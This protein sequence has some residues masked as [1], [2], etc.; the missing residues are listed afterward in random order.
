VLRGAAAVIALFVL[1]AAALTVARVY[2]QRTLTTLFARYLAADVDPLPIVWPNPRV[3]VL[4]LENL[5]PPVDPQALHVPGAVTIRSAF[6]RLEFGGQAC[7]GRSSYVGF[8]YEVPFNGKLA[9]QAVVLQWSVPPTGAT[10]RLFVPIYRMLIARPG[11]GELP[12]GE[13]RLLDL[14]L[15]PEH[16][17]C[18]VSL[19]TVHRPSD[20]PIRLLLSLGPDWQEHRQYQTL[21]TRGAANT[22]G[23]P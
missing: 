10:D 15:L 19:A 5:L 8:R 2:Q 6:L 17:P 23:L 11:G 12:I 9:Q 20:F 16:M 3:S 14:E 7:A 4:P 1:P 22:P 21:S 13:L 18:L